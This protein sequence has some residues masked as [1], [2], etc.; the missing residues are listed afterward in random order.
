MAGVPMNSPQVQVPI[1]GTPLATLADWLPAGEPL[2]WRYNTPAKDLTSLAA[3]IVA[4]PVFNTCMVTRVWNWA[5]SR[6]NVVDDGATL[7][8]DLATQLTTQLTGNNGNLKESIRSAFKSDA[9][10]KF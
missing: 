2:S 7:T 3:A 9:F 10:V 5:M 6:P 1:P 4:D 8:P